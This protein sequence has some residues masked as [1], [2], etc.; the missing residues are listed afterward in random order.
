M[1]GREGVLEEVTVK[2]KKAAVTHGEDCS[3][4]REQRMEGTILTITW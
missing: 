1:G 4:K 2:L 3:G